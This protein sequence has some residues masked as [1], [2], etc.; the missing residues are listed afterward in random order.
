MELRT[1]RHRG[2]L[3]FFD[4]CCLQMVC[5]IYQILHK[6]KCLVCTTTH[7]SSVPWTLG[8]FCLSKL[9]QHWEST[10]GL[11]FVPFICPVWKIA[12]KTEDPRQLLKWYCCD[13]FLTWWNPTTKDAQRH[14]TNAIHNS[15]VYFNGLANQPFFLNHKSLQQFLFGRICFWKNVFCWA[16]MVSCC[17]LANSWWFSV[18]CFALFCAFVFWCFIVCCDY[19][20]LVRFECHFVAELEITASFK[21]PTRHS[22]GAGILAYRT[23]QYSYPSQ[24]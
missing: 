5:L 1:R 2:I 16:V 15:K 12:S 24:N 14:T 21:R 18:V 17:W 11:D 22:R 13:W 9:W 6:C 8:W 3:L 7:V 19:S 4:A 20:V 10:K 23:I